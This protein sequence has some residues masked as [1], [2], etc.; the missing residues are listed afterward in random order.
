[1]SFDDRAQIFRRIIR[2]RLAEQENGFV[3]FFRLL[4]A[5]PVPEGTARIV[6]AIYEDDLTEKFPA[7]LAYVSG[8]NQSVANDEAARRL[9]ARLSSFQPV[10]DIQ[11]LAELSDW[12][13]HGDQ[14]V[15]A[16]RQP[17]D[18]VD[19]V[20]ELV[21]PALCDAAAKADMSALPVPVHLGSAQRYEDVKVI[22]EPSAPPEPG[23]WSRVLR[24]G[25]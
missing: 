15:P 12:E 16:L 11:Q 9:H 14:Q 23:F 5:T 7:L 21:I 1:M 2:D 24:K 17:Y 4:A 25:Q 13:M 20:G 6:I 19:H 22:Y 3:Q 8:N 10:I 18:N